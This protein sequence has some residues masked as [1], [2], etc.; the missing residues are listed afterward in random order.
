MGLPA[1]VVF[2]ACGECVWGLSAHA[3]LGAGR[4]ALPPELE[5]PRV[6]RESRC[7]AEGPPRTAGLEDPEQGG[8]QPG[9]LAMELCA[10]QT[11]CVSL[12]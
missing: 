11:L 6:E 5:H 3:A 2:E 1:W 8:G 7:D 12:R 9:V 10:C 4:Q